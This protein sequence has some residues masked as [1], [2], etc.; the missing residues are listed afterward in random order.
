MGPVFCILEARNS[1][2]FSTILK[3][4]MTLSLIIT[5]VNLVSGILSAVIA[6]HVLSQDCWGDLTKFFLRPAVVIVMLSFSAA[7][8]FMM[9]LI[10]AVILFLNN[11][12]G[13][14]HAIVLCCCLFYNLWQ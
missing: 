6:A 3:Y 2:F 12:S 10:N 11:C 14:I 7:V 8:N 1:P 4:S 5:I 13:C 9:I